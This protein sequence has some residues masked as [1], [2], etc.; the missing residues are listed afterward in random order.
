MTKHTKNFHP[1]EVP[2][3]DKKK[4][5]VDPIDSDDSVRKRDQKA[6]EK[7]KIKP[8][9][10]KK[11]ELYCLTGNFGYKRV[12]IPLVLRADGFTR[13]RYVQKNTGYLVKGSDHANK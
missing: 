10:T 12:L 8:E 6:Q 4:L 2:A 5:L 7:K 11:W 13:C 3:K 1:D 9:V